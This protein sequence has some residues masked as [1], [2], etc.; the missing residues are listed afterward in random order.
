MEEQYQ[1][2]IAELE[3]ELKKTQTALEGQEQKAREAQERYVRLYAEF[4][5]FRKRSA[6]DLEEARHAGNVKVVK[7]ILPVLD[8][9]E[10]AL[11]HA[12][13]A[14]DKQAIVEGVELV[15]RQFLNAL[16]KIGVKPLEARGQPFDPNFHEAMAHHESDEHEPDTV[17]EEY[18]RGY[19]YGD[20]LL[21]P[22]LVTVA[23]PSEDK[24]KKE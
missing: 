7:E 21:R 19:L 13:E 12:T 4:E 16:E 9:L 8:D 5:N 1:R 3:E 15:L 17:V 10:R 2:R 18:R 23:K 6:K 20:K 22:A 14:E 11:K 24:D